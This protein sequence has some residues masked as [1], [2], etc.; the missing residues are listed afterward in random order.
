MRLPAASRRSREGCADT[1]G[2]LSSRAI[3]GSCRCPTVASVLHVYMAWSKS[4]TEA[5]LHHQNLSVSPRISSLSV[6]ANLATSLP[7]LVSGLYAR[8]HAWVLTL[9]SC[10]RRRYTRKGALLS[11]FSVT[12]QQF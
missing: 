9:T 11:R 10:G 6:R 12:G 1:A 2:R 4:A 8:H 3:A 7:L 5:P